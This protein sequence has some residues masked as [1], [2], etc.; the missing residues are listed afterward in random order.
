MKFVPDELAVYERNPHYYGEVPYF[1][2][3][4]LKGG[5]DALSA[6]KSV[7]E[8]GKADYAWNL[9]IDPETLDNMEAVGK[10]KVVSAFSSLVERIVLN[11]TN[12]DSGLG[13]DRS[14][15]LEGSNPH[16]FLTFTP[17]ARA[18]SMAVDRTLLSERLYGSPGEPTCD[19]IVGPPIY[20]SDASGGLSCPRHIRGEPDAR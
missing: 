13:E 16:P 12:S 18:M 2:K 20:A 9:Q 7:M 17:I 8:T 4:V 5:G 10:G 11:Q 1:D 15:Y 14:E 3:V 6:A 19:L